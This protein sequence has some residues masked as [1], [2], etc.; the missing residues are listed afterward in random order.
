MYSA[1]R[2]PPRTAT[3]RPSSRSLER[4]FTCAR[5]RSPELVWADEM[6]AIKRSSDAV[7][8]D[9]SEQTELPV[10]ILGDEPV[11]FGAQET[12]NASFL[13]VLIVTNL[14]HMIRKI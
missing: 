3:P 2:S 13:H 10:A 11:D 12:P 9:L 7:F 8:I 14:S 1:A 6:K 4:N 5:I